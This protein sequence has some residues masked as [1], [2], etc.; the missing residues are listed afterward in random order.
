[1]ED[2][3]PMTFPKIYGFDASLRLLKERIEQSISSID[4]LDSRA[5]PLREIAHLI[6]NR[7]K[8]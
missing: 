7:V 6:V 4:F 5:E 3:N 1:M 2:T 8:K